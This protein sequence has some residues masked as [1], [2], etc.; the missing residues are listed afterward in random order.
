MFAKHSIHTPSVLQQFS[1]PPQG[2][3]AH[4]T[5]HILKYR[6][7]CFAINLFNVLLKSNFYGYVNRLLH[8]LVFLKASL[9]NSIYFY[10][11]QRYLGGNSITVLEGLE[12]LDCLQ[13][14]YIEN[15]K[16]AKGEK[17]LFD[18]RT[19]STLSVSLVS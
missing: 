3:F 6:I 1:K 12:E 4:F 11:C 9:W 16:L 19:M 5:Y 2:S 15:Q 8:M 10:L 17:L 13:E 7:T 18:P 14:L